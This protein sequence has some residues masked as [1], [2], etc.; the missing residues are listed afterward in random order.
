M[1]DPPIN[2]VGASIVSFLG[3]RYPI[4]KIDNGVLV[5]TV[6]GDI[7]KSLPITLVY[8]NG[9]F[10]LQNVATSGKLDKGANLKAANARVLEQQIEVLQSIPHRET[11]LMYAPHTLETEF[12]QVDPLIK[13]IT[14]KENASAVASDVVEVTYT[15]EQWKTRRAVKESYIKIDSNDYL[16]YDGAAS[17]D[18]K[19]NSLMIVMEY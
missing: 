3:N 7:L 1:I 5:E 15:R 10:K 11:I 12:V 18:P 8:D 16:I 17:G 2:S 6:E 14:V 19:D 9:V 13:N 4:K